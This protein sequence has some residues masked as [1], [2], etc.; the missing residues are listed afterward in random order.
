[1]NDLLPPALRMDVVSLVVLMTLLAAAAWTDI[2][3][4]RVPN[5]LVV[6]GLVLG[7]A[8]GLAPGGI[9]AKDM[10]LGLVTGLALFLPC[11]ALGVMGAGDVKLMAMAGT[12]LG[13]KAT[14]LAGVTTFAAGGVLAI[15]YGL[16]SGVLRQAL[17]NVW[18]FAGSTVVHL[19]S[20]SAPRIADMPITRVRLPYAAAVAAGV[21]VSL[22]AADRY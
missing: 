6:A 9:G 5:A 14:L 11:Y 8:F 7:I 19:A 2:R 20:G 12:F 13:V 16:K 4:K 18:R 3:S 22:L 17:G 21:L 1:M 10:A 15:G